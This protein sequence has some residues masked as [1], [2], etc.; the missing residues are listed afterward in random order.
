[1][2]QS[3]AV[4]KFEV[5]GY[6]HLS[7]IF[8]VTLHRGSDGMPWYQH[9]DCRC[10][11]TL[12]LGSPCIHVVFVVFIYLPSLKKNNNS[13][14]PPSQCGPF[15]RKW[16]AFIYDAT[17]L[18]KQYGEDVATIF[19]LIFILNSICCCRIVA[20]VEVDRKRRQIAEQSKRT[21]KSSSDQN[22]LICHEDDLVDGSSGNETCSG[23]GSG[24]MNDEVVKEDEVL[25]FLLT[26]RA[27]VLKRISSTCSSGGKTGHN[28]CRY[29]SKNVSVILPKLVLLPSSTCMKNM[30]NG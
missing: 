10:G 5:I 19:I 22:I 20:T 27:M 25:I 16:Y 24:D 7:L 17:V 15:L 8:P 2:F 4:L 14:F 12:A 3:D 11:Y 6:G 18:E 1:M 28:Q 26:E 30:A 13:Q 29:N 9:V 21:Q 23:N